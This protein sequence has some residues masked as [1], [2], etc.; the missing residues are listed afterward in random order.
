MM[1]PPIVHEVVRTLKAYGHITAVHKTSD[2]EAVNSVTVKWTDLSLFA[3]QLAPAGVQVSREHARETRGRARV[4]DIYRELS[5]PMFRTDGYETGL[6]WDATSK[7]VPEVGSFVSVTF[8]Q[9]VRQE[10]TESRRGG[11]GA[12]MSS[13]TP[14]HVI[15]VIAPE[16][17]ET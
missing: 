1:H 2:G 14:G 3:C 7:S 9:R 5:H 16:A 15:E 6:Y 4:P 12:I 10:T 17:I 11:A 8:T 13:F